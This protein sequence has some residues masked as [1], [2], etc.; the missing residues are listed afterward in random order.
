M[1]TGL[2]Y[3]TLWL[4]SWYM[5]IKEHDLKLNLQLHFNV[6]EYQRVMSMTTKSYAT[7]LDL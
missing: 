5:W 3:S 6:K 4:K 2:R 7:Y 1:N